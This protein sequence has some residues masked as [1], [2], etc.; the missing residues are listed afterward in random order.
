MDSPVADR[1]NIKVD[2]IPEVRRPPSVEEMNIL[3]DNAEFALL[4][5]CSANDIQKTLR[6]ERSDVRVVQRNLDAV[7]GSYSIIW[8]REKVSNV[9]HRVIAIPGSRNLKNM[10]TNMDNTLEYDDILKIKVHKG[11]SLA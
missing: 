2:S 6:R 3:I 10:Q 1:Q 8:Y 9:I 4:S 5:Y 7:G 11:T